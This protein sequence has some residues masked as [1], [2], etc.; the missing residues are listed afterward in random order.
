MTADVDAGPV[1][2]PLD[3]ATDGLDAAHLLATYWRGRKI[4]LDVDQLARRSVAVLVA[5]SLLGQLPE[6]EAPLDQ[7]APTV[8]PLPYE[9]PPLS[10]NDRGH[11]TARHREVREVRDT[12]RWTLRAARLGR[13]DRVEVGLHWRPARNGRRDEDNLVATLKVCCDAAVDEGLG[14]DDTPRWMR[15]LMPEIHP[16]DPD[17]PGAVWLTVAVLV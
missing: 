1:T 16:A 5:A 6:P 8:I 2:A 10:L 3:P 4:P 9:Q 17:R 11:W 12:I 13:H 14:R 7:P 15:K